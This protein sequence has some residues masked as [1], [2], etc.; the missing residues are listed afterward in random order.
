MNNSLVTRA[1]L[2]LGASAAAL[3]IAAVIFDRFSIGFFS[4]PIV[5]VIFT[6]VGL[7]AK[8]VA[9]AILERSA[10]QASWASGLLGTWLTLLVTDLVS[11]GLQIEGIFTWVMS[12]V[13]VW[14]GLLAADVV[15]E[16]VAKQ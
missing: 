10:Q 5:V 11:D 9:T 1:G 6:L 12:T 15:T 14:L 2:S 16:Q 3:L 13:I 4:F 8:P 7:A